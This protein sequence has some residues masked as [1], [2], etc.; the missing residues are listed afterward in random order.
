MGLTRGTVVRI[1]YGGRTIDGWVVIASP[2]EDS[3]MLGFEGSLPGPD[4]C[5]FFLGSMPVLRDKRSGEYL[6]LLHGE[7]VTIIAGGLQ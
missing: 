2:N 6:D 7:P 5:G 3:L 4:E 1:T